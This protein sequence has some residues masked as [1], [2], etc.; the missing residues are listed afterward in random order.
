MTKL[1]PSLDPGL[2]IDLVL[3]NIICFPLVS[4]TD[5]IRYVVPVLRI[6]DVNLGTGYFPSW[7]QK[8]LSQ[9]TKNRSIYNVA[10]LLCSKKK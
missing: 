2:L 4:D 1:S 7:I 9:L 3:V 6:R 10:M 8:I 5:V